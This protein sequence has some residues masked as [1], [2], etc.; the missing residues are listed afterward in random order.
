VDLH[1]HTNASDG[2]YSP[3]EVVGKAVA[4]EISVLSITDHDTIG[5][6]EE[7]AEAAKAFSN[8]VLIPGVEINT[9]V[10]SG[11]A[12]ILGYFIDRTH[13]ELLALLKEMRVSR[14]NRAQKMLAKLEVLGMPLSWD[15]VQEIASTDSIGRPHI[16][17]A[18]LE[19]G[20]ITSLREAFDKYL[21]FGKPAYV[22]RSK[23]SP[24]QATELILKASGLPVLAHP[25][26]VSEPEKMISDLKEHGLAGIEVYYGSYSNS[27]V[28]HL[29]SFA[30]KYDLLVT[31][32]SDFHGLDEATEVGL[33]RSGMP[34]KAARAL[35][36][37]GE[38]QPGG[39]RAQ[40]GVN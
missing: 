12:H 32:G 28:T 5:G 15:R 35:I 3:S 36:A 13:P 11:E 1:V 7:A 40:R 34:M 8:L 25:F 2:R 31:G 20:Y 29:R 39:R 14:H 10:P 6:L 33:G 9:D 18:L 38:Q 4:A 37:L 23:V 30:Q 17:Q 16:A 26:T 22:P 24:A 27:E 21:G 19:K